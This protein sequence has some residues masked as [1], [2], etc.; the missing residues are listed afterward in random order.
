MW[1][2]L[3]KQGKLTEFIKNKYSLTSDNPIMED[4]STEE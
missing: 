2:M 3:L 4:S 1:M